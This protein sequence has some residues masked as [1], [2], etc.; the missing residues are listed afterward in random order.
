LK[1]KVTLGNKFICSSVRASKTIKK[2]KKFDVIKK[3][4]DIIPIIPCYS[5]Q[6][7]GKIVEPKTGR[8]FEQRSKRIEFNR[9]EEKCDCNLLIFS[10]EGVVGDVQKQP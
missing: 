5:F 10:F 6:G 8:I 3:N 1:D 4:S 7:K 9:L 2:P